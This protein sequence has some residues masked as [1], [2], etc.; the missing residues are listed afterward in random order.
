MNLYKVVLVDDEEEIRKG[1]IRRIKWEELDFTIVGEAENGIEALEIIEKMTP[2]LVITDIKMPFKDGIQLAEEIRYRFPTIK[3]IILS[4]FDDFEYARDALTLGV[5]RYILKPINAIEMN[6]LL[7]EIKALLDEEILSRRNLNTLKLT[8]KKSLPLLKERFL[9]HWIESYVDQEAIKENISELDLSIKDGPLVVVIIRPDEMIKMEVKQSA[10]KN[11]NIL[12]L[13]ISNICEEIIMKEELGI[14]FARRNELIVVI[15]LEEGE[16]PKSSSRLFRGLEQIRIAIKK[17]LNTTITI[18]VG[19]I[20]SDPTLI[21]KSYG[22]A[23]SALDYSI[24]VG[25]NKIIYIDDIEPNQSIEPLLEEKDEQTLLT[26]IKLGQEE[27]IMSVIEK[28]F[29]KLDKECLALREY[30]I[31]IVGLLASIMKLGHSMKLDMSALLPQEANFLEALSQLRTQDEMKTWLL[32]ICLAIARTLK[33]TRKEIKN[34]LIEKAVAY[35]LVHYEDEQLSADQLCRYLHISPNYFSALF[36]K[37]MEM[38]FTSYLT[39][40]R[41]DQAKKLLQTTDKKTAEIGYAVGYSEGHYFSYVF[42]K[43]TGYAPT[44]YRNGKI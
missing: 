17:Y 6:T 31:Y 35:I 25:T 19:N 23:A 1:I 14:L 27:K 13:A 26:V 38:T 4:G 9:N 20:C 28:L 43:T 3:V 10:I 39:Q 15:S 41:I 40:I 16:S 29:M 34:E 7:R 44:E 21:Y 42:K 37:E 32:Y 30:Q 8:Y 12:K 2:D 18:G 36:K 11:K 22:A 5:M 33:S 24:T